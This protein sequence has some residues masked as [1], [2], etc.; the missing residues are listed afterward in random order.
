MADIA[1]YDIAIIG[2]GMV[3][4][5]LA[6][7]L[8]SSLSIAVIESFPLPSTSTL[9]VNTIQPSFDNRATAL[10]KS[11][12]HFF[13]KA[14]MWG[15]IAPLC[16][17]IKDVH[18]SDKGF[19]GSALLSEAQEP[20]ENLGFVIENMA[21]GKLIFSHISQ[22]K[23]IHF[24]SP[25]TVNNVTVQADGVL[26]QYLKNDASVE[27]LQAKLIV[28]ADGANSS[29]CKKLG[30]NTQT[31]ENAHTAIVTNV[32]TSKP[33]QHIAYERFTETGPMALLPLLSP[34]DETQR[35]A[36][37][38]TLPT[39]QAELMLALDEEQFLRHL[40]QCFGHFQGDFIRCGQRF[41]YPLLLTSAAEQVRNHIVVMGNAAHS[42][43]PVAGQGFNLA[44]RDV[45]CF[46][47][48]IAEA[49]ADEKPWHKLEVLELYQQAQKNDQALTTMFSDSLP[50]LF[51]NHSIPLAA[52]RN[53]GLLALELLPSVKTQFVSFATGYR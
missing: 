30:V 9:D 29:I 48:V 21:L 6:A 19:W 53:M 38:W 32:A 2:G 8:P 39:E 15:A 20:L 28:V 13:E 16:E 22:R 36:L 27:A 50:Q 35:S 37:I 31:H 25:A 51:S 26:L 41:S 24:I 44:L 12:Q 3:G 46:V 7:L 14:G 47:N 52:G 4:A 43:H 40:Q 42:L 45:E 1:K 11:S 10:S 49:M 34:D 5:S 17:S 23:N 18:V 33:H